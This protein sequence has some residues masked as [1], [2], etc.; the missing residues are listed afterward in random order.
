MIILRFFLFLALIVYGVGLILRWFL[1]GVHLGKPA[2]NRTR[3][4]SKSD[5]RD[6]TDQKIDDADYEEL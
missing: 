1:T 5:Y 6:L 4:K 3:E 2:K